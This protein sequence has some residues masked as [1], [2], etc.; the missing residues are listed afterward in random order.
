VLGVRVRTS[1]DELRV[2]GVPARP[3]GGATVDAQ[4]D[5]RMAMLAAIAGLVSR[6][7][8]EL[9]G[10]ESV[11]VSYPGFFAVLDSLALR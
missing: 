6:E 10:A 4:G 2:R 11:A 7:G 8:L 5:H 1:D 3:R 9:R